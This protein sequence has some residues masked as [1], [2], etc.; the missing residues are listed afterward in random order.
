MAV[1]ED[2]SSMFAA[3]CGQLPIEN[4]SPM[5]LEPFQQR[6]L[7]DYFAGVTETLILLPKKNGKSTL[8]AALGLFH[9]CSTPDAECVIAA[10]SRDQAALIL[11]QCQG[12]IRRS[13]GLAGRL[14]VTQR[15]IAHLTLGGRVRVRADRHYQHRR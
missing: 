10:T 12:F 9:L 3:F 13:P 6:L 15:E 14:R 7:A 5:R 2:E 1:P 8:L 11:R 4:G